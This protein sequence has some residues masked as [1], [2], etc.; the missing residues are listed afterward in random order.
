MT[1][2]RT[3]EGLTLVGASAGTGKTYRLTKEVEGAL[4]G[5]AGPP[6]RPEGL[7]AVTYTRKAQVELESRIRRSLLGSKVAGQA[8]QLPQAYLGTVHAVCLRWVR[9]LALDAGVAPNIE[10]LADEGLALSTVLEE[11]VSP[12]DREELD[13]LAERLQM[14]INQQ[15]G[16]VYWDQPV[17]DIISLARSGRIRPAALADMARRSAETYLALFTGPV[18]DGP[19]LDRELEAQVVR[20]LAAIDPRTDVT[21]QTR[22]A[23]DALK[24][25]LRAARAGKATWAQWTKLAHLKAGK[26]SEP[27]I[28]PVHE[29]ASRWASHPDL[30]ADIRRFTELVYRAAAATLDLYA[31]WKRERGLLDYVDM[32]DAALSLLEDPEVASDLAEK[33]ELVVVDE[34]QDSSPIQLLLFLRLH[35]IAGRSTWVGDPK[36]CIFEYAGA[37]P[38][39]MDAV[40]HW[41]RRSGGTPDRLTTNHR[42]RPSLV[43]LCN[44]VFS[45]ALARYG[46]PAE[47]VRV[48]A[49]RSAADEAEL[50]RL[51][52]MGLFYF[53]GAQQ[54]QAESLAAG[55]SR[56]LARPEETMVRDPVHGALRPVEPH[57][58]AVLVAT[59]SEGKL[60]ADAL[61]RLGLGATFDRPGLLATPE[62]VAMAA[63]LRFVLDPRDSLAVAE[64]EALHGWNGEGAE[65]WLTR[66]LASGAVSKARWR[67]KLDNRRPAALVLSPQELVEAVFVAIDLPALCARWPNPALRIANLDALW[68]FARVYEQRCI[69]GGEGCSLSGLLRFL[70]SL[71]RATFRHG[72]ERRADQQH[73]GS[74]AACVTVMTY[75]R[76]KGLE[77]PVVILSS[78][79]RGP[80]PA[81]FDVAPEKSASELDPDHPLEGRWIRYWPWPFGGAKAELRDWAEQSEVGKVEIERE[82]SERA[83]LLYVGFT[84]A[85]DHLVLAAKVTKSVPQCAWLDELTFEGKPA[86]ALPRADS[87]TSTVEI[88][89]PLARSVP[90]RLF[91]LEPSPAEEP[92]EPARS[93]FQ[94]APV[95]L[96]PPYW[97]RPSDGEHESLGGPELRIR[98]VHHPIHPPLVRA[99]Q[100]QVLWSRVGD[101][102]HAFLAADVEGLTREARER[103]AQ[104]LIEAFEVGDAYGPHRFLEASD[105]FTTFVRNRVPDARWMRE[106]PIEARV[107]TPEGERAIDGRIDLL[108]E[109]DEAF[110]IVDHK[111]FPGIGEAVWRAKAEELAPQLAVY[112]RALSIARPDKPASAWLHFATGGAIV[113]FDLC[114]A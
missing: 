89:G 68:R 73:S 6:I 111:S 19:K 37:D 59:N 1:A 16:Q 83:R 80:R 74:D 56:L 100:A 72:E 54:R 27:A 8:S 34:L 55:I 38:S 3:A 63:A 102:L 69:D 106:V 33:L 99:T 109:T 4:T 23:I 70:D 14:H 49:H 13:E 45:G 22:E 26:K 108:L 12:D 53:D 64:L 82:S 86:V 87:P 91:H 52:A 107:G 21:K 78:L 20:A 47:D 85:R 36:Q 32:I 15:E 112:A 81:I 93:W 65:A 88:G 61:A 42:S 98:E 77:W 110:I 28:L 101:A 96:R 95:P 90:A 103:I 57:D 58:I 30:R 97:I 40:I 35:Q 5:D 84:R 44:A 62:G 48:G 41:V 75:H 105:A 94:R 10:V 39:L 17:E 11:T 66:R 2:R 104:R 9:E 29:A 25:Y 51:P 18:D 79:D 113:T 76:S 43:E 60:V 31:S 7:V 67:D 92:K 71:T 114:A 24:D 46:V 50:G